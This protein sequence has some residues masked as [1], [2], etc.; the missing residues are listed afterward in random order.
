[1]F[2][3]I[4]RKAKVFLVVKKSKYRQTVF[5]LQGGIYKMWG[6][7]YHGLKAGEMKIFIPRPKG[8]GN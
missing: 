6:D 5:Y 7:F 3:H 8:R 4:D 2:C 1:M